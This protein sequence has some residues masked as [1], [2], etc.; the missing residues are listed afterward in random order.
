[1]GSDNKPAVEPPTPSGKV[2][3]RWAPEDTSSFIKPFAIM[4]GTCG[5][6]QVI[7]TGL[8]YAVYKF[9]ATATYSD[10]MV[11]AIAGG[12]YWLYAGV[13]VTAYAMRFV[14]MYPMVFKERVMKGALREEI[15]ANMRSNPYV[16]KSVGASKE[17][18]LFDNEGV[19]GKY[20]RANRSL[21]HM[22]ENFGSVL[23]G[24]ALAGSVFP[25]PAYVCACFF[26][27]GRIVH[28]VGYTSG[29]G[30]HGLGFM[31]STLSQITLEGLVALVALGGFGLLTVGSAAPSVE[32]RVA[33]L[34]AAL[35]GL[36][37]AAAAGGAA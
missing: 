35:K 29:Y 25:F 36:K 18:V 1:M 28:Q 14:N 17:T 7:G 4:L 21:T 6:F 3:P 30:G 37:A 9:G 24:L 15:G 2:A 8:A 16:F 12:G 20:N 32:A 13:V 22:I 27:V 19:I 11:A 26:A 31:I 23:V 33:A 34:E 10:K 5:I